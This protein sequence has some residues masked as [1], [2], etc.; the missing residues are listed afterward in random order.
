VHDKGDGER[1]KEHDAVIEGFTFRV[2]NFQSFTPDPLGYERISVGKMQAS[3][4]SKDVLP[5]LQK[6]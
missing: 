5:N 2:E 1:E 3:R 4:I 6:A